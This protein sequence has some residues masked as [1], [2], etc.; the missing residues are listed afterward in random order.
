MTTTSELNNHRTGKCT[1]LDGEIH[2]IIS[3]VHLML[4]RSNNAGVDFAEIVRQFLDRS[5]T[6]RSKPVLG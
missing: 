3:A 1:M 4:E 5:L 6:P 2:T